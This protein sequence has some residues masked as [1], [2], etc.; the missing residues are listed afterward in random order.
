[1]DHNPTRHRRLVTS[2]ELW[3]G[4]SLMAR[5]RSSVRKPAFAAGEFGATCHATTPDCPSIHDTPS[6][7]AVNIDRCWKLMMPKTMA[8]R[9]ARA[10]T[11]APNRT[12][13][14]SLIG[15]LTDYPYKIPPKDIFCN[16][17]SKLYK[18]SQINNHMK[19]NRLHRDRAREGGR[20]FPPSI[21]W[22]ALSCF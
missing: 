8:A 11:A 6:S 12:R 15:A 5:S 1:M 2:I 21:L 14:L 17:A 20:N 9:V 7:G 19:F 16:P 13:R 18:L 10:R 22:K 4:A 3:M